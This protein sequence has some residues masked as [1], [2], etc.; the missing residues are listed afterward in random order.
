M[1]TKTTSKTT[2]KKPA[3]RA[4]KAKAIQRPTQPKKPARANVP[5]TRRKPETPPPPSALQSAAI[6]LADAPPEGL[7]TKAMVEAMALRGLWTS[8][9]GKTPEATVYAGI[10]REIGRK[11]NTA[12]FRKVSRG[13][14]ALNT[15]LA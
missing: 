11:G 5:V 3:S 15:T 2:T 6:V 7:S 13:R 1:P 10:L 9:E 8:P 12:R 4:T 14:F